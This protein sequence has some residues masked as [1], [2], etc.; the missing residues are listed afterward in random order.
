M[1]FDDNVFTEVLLILFFFFFFPLV[2]DR[3]GLNSISS[4]LN[5]K[6]VI[7]TWLILT[8]DLVSSHNGREAL[9]YVPKFSSTI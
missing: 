2:A 3:Y 8:E 4:M 7:A 6:L 5:R 9:C 1:H